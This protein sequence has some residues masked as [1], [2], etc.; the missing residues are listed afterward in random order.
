MLWS[1]F[2]TSRDESGKRIMKSR[3][4]AV[5]FGFVSANVYNQRS[6]IRN[7]EHHSRILRTELKLEVREVVI[8]VSDTRIKCWNEKQVAKIKSRKYGLM[9]GQVPVG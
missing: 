5:N 3:R 8:L 9:D 2:L 7:V 1:I 4:V 6:N